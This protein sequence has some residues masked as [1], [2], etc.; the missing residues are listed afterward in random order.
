MGFSMTVSEYARHRGCDEKAVRKAIDA[1]R[2]TAL[3]DGRGR[4]IDP[5]VADIQWARNT[6]ARADSAR[7]AA[8]GASAP[9]DAPTAPSAAAPAASTPAGADYN[10]HRTRREKAEA[11]K[12]EFEAQRLAGSLI[13]RD[14]AERAVIEAFRTLR[15]ACMSSH[16][17]TAL[18][19]AG[20]TELREIRLVLDD[21]YRQAFADAESRMAQL[22]GRIA[23]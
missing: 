14:R 10:D 21:G 20:L 15:D 23:A 18:R 7:P 4:R 6:R 17:A 11:D 8:S 16:Q 19:V 3:G 22:L 9:G 5:D 12:A 13:E 2:I 1:G